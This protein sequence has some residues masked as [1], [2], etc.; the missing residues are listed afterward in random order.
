MRRPRL[1][2]QRGRAGED[3]SHSPHVPTNAAEDKKKVV[4]IDLGGA[5]VRS[6]FT[7]PTTLCSCLAPLAQRR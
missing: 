6:S 7:R 2:L 3:P 5:A 4:L 1:C